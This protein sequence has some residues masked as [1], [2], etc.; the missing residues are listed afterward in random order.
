MFVLSEISV[1]TKAEG[2]L[3]SWKLTCSGLCVHDS[4]GISRILFQ[5]HRIRLPTTLPSLCKIP[6]T[7]SQHNRLKRSLREIRADPLWFF[8]RYANKLI[9]G[10]G[11]AL[12]FYDMLTCGEG[13]IKWGDGLVWH[14]SMY[15]KDAHGQFITA[16]FPPRIGVLQQ[17]SA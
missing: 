10:V 5:L 7:K 8:S 3:H 16:D 12:A 13:K 2:D 17:L 6:S 15:W 4:C 1:S 11:L 9:P 14:K